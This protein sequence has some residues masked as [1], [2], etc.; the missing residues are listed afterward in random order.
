MRTLLILFLSSLASLAQTVTLPARVSVTDTNGAYQWPKDATRVIGPLIDEW[1]I[2]SGSQSS[3]KT[4]W[5][6]SLNSGVIDQQ[7]ETNRFGVTTLSTT[8][9]SSAAPSATTAA[10]GFA[11]SD[12][13]LLSFEA[14]I[15]TPSALSDGT[16]NYT[17]RVG[18]DDGGADVA[19]WLYN[20][21]TNSGNWTCQ[22]IANNVGTITSSGQAVTADTWHKLKTVVDMSVP[23]VVFYLNGTA[24]VTNTSNIPAGASRR[25][26]LRMSIVKSA[27]TAARILGIDR[28]EL[29]VLTSVP[30]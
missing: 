20:H 5:I 17:I 28:T 13:A 26:E 7:A 12:T 30:R 15:K 6:I 14:W 2:D 22:T 19:G 16:D 8:T 29:N 11:F 18:W 23:R 4:G 27:G 25:T 3:Q 1:F 21:S 24:V 10:D 9:S